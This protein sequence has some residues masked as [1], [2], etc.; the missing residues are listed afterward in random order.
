MPSSSITEYTFKYTSIIITD[1]STTTKE[2]LLNVW[3]SKIENTGVCD[4]NGR[5]HSS[6]NSTVVIDESRTTGE[7]KIRKDEIRVFKAVLPAVPDRH[8]KR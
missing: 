3:S 2:A 1:F 8:R 7:F 4:R 5:N 6:A